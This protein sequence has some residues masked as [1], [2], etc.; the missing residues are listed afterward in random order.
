MWET[1]FCMEIMLVI[2]DHEMQTHGILTWEVSN[3][4]VYVWTREI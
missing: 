3:S 2:F 1:G 4:E